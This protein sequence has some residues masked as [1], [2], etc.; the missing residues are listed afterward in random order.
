MLERER[1]ELCRGGIQAD[2]MG[3][4]KTIQT[5]AVICGNKVQRTLIVTTVSTVAQWRDALIEFG[6]IFPVIVQSSYRG[7]LPEP[8][9]E[10]PLVVVTAYSSFMRPGHPF[11][12]VKWSRVVLD[13][14]HVIRNPKTKLFNELSQLDSG[15]KWILSGTPVQNSP[16]E[17]VTLAKW[18]G[19]ENSSIEYIRAHYLIRR[20]QESEAKAN[21]RLALPP[22]DTQVIKLDFRYDYE[23]DAYTSLLSNPITD[24]T[25]AIEI[26]TRLRQVCS[27][28][29]N[30][31]KRVR[32]NE[33]SPSTK[34]EYLCN[35]I[36]TANT[37]C[38]VFCTWTNEITLI[39]RELNRL[40]VPCLVF[41]GRLSR[42]TKDNVIYN[43]KH[44]AIQ[45]LLL[46]INCGST[47]LNLQVSNRVYIVSPHWNPCVELQAIGRAYRKGQT[48][49]VTCI[50]LVIKDTIEE[51]CLE[52]QKRKL[53]F[54]GGDTGK[55]L[56]IETDDDLLNILFHSV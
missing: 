5:I 42:D 2:D 30:G 36:V 6:D 40:G 32:N 29:C 55:R 12:A 21:P 22:L 54:I 34:I 15:I 18:I 4:G 48:S 35:D 31:K 46:Q 14:G 20:T 47:G 52:L 10:T 26:L 27:G 33:T 3:L 49:K 24:K 17:L 1:G 7:A 44:S 9:E 53:G 45:V 41:D 56:G 25:T 37:K 28:N 8:T 11:K 43:F 51:K 19:I 38:L 50:R 23:R 16:K 39:Q 13:E